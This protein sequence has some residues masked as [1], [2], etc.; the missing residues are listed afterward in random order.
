[1]AQWTQLLALGAFFVSSLGFCAEP[2][3]LLFV[4]R[5][6]P[7]DEAAFD[8]LLASFGSEL[9]VTRCHLPLDQKM[10]SPKLAE[11]IDV[12]LFYDQDQTPLSDEDQANYA[13]LFESGVGIFAL[14]HH[15]SA[16]PEWPD[17]WR[18][19]GGCYVFEQNRVIDGKEL[20]LGFY[21]HDQT[22]DVTVSDC[23]H[24]ITEGVDDFTICDETYGNAYVAPNAQVLLSTDHEK[25]T[26]QL[27]WLW[28]EHVSPVLTLML[29]HDAKAYENP[30]FRQIF[31]QAIRWLAAESARTK[32]SF[33]R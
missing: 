26:K 18:L 29:G 10:L 8:E 5:G 27:A 32:A 12:V 33:K 6:H 31:I 11:T 22:I 1:M 25:S 9:A 30:Q 17:F 23:A 7:Y 3:R 16:H 14:H 4:D 13:A 28:N 24:P 20:P 2:I 15:L 21:D 19:T